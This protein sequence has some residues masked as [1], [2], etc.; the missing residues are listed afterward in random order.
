MIIEQNVTM[1]VSTCKVNE[2][3]RPKCNQFWPASQEQEP[4]YSI[5][6][7]DENREKIK[8]KLLDHVQESKYLERRE[9]EAQRADGSVH[10]LTQIHFTGWPDHGVPEGAAV[11]AFE[12]MLFKFINWNLNSQA[13]EKSIVHCSA[14]I[15]RTGTTISLMETIINICAQRNAGLDPEFSLFHTV[16]RLREQRYG[17]VQ[18]YSQYQFMYNFL[19]SWLQKTFK[20]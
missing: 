3:G 15:G 17:S 1:I 4:K 20:K 8:I 6:Q 14:G 13:N 2:N 12:Q 19:A 7:L 9:M 18:T 11:A 16:R 5:S 10:K